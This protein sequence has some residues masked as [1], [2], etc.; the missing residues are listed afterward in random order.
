MSG[1]KIASTPP[2]PCDVRPYGR[3]ANRRRIGREKRQRRHHAGV[4]TSPPRHVVVCAGLQPRNVNRV[5]TFAHAPEPSA[6]RLPCGAI[7]VCRLH[8][9]AF[10]VRPFQAPFFTR[11][12]ER[13]VQCAAPLSFHGG[14]ILPEALRF[15]SETAPPQGGR[16]GPGRDCRKRYACQTAFRM[17]A[18]RPASTSPG[19]RRP[20]RLAPGRFGLHGGPVRD[21]RRVRRVR[22][23]VP[24]RPSW[25]TAG[26]LALRGRVCPAPFP[27]VAARPFRTPFLDPPAGAVR[28]VRRTPPA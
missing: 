24:A 12:R 16:C 11:R 28:P 20:P 18:H 2:S 1:Q 14:R 6:D 10:S 7:T 21:T 4:R 25:P 8:S 22:A 26:A 19:S 23:A 3:C 5:P 9:R 15:P 13:C 17:S 27:R